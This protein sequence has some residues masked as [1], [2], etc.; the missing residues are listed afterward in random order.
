MK[1]KPSWS[2]LRFFVLSG[3]LPLLLTTGIAQTRPPVV[4][5]PGYISTKLL[6]TVENQ[7]VEPIALQAGLSKPGFLATSQTASVLPAVTSS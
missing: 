1:G 4:L 7:T 2:V 6:V 5:F 3:G